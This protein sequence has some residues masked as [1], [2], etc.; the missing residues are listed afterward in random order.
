MKP[1]TKYMN[2][3]FFNNIGANYDDIILNWLLGLYGIVTH[4]EVERTLSAIDEK[5]FNRYIDIDSEYNISTPS[6]KRT[7]TELWLR[8][9]P[10]DIDSMPGIVHFGNTIILKIIF[11][12]F[13]RSDFNKLDALKGRL[14]SE[15]EAIEFNGCDVSDMKFLKGVKHISSLRMY[16]SSVKSFDGIDGVEIDVMHTDRM[17][18]TDGGDAFSTMPK[19]SG[20]IF[21]TGCNDIKN[22]TGIKNSLTPGTKLTICRCN[23]IAKCDLSG[24]TLNKISGDDSIFPIFSNPDMFPKKLKIIEFDTVNDLQRLNEIKKV[25]KKHYPSSVDIYCVRCGR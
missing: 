19:M 5:I 24:Q 16:E 8:I 4:G 20:S 17:R 25:I 14:P 10:K 15:I 23:N 13:R 21:I 18:S 9:Y 3:G 7:M 22:L 12:D 2:K 6:N 1:I 11:C